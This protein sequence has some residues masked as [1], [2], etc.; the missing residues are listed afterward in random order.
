[1]SFQSAC[2]ELAKSIKQARDDA[3]E[4]GSIR[5]TILVNFGPTSQ[6]LSRYGF[7][8]PTE[9]PENTDSTEKLLFFVLKE[10]KKRIEKT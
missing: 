9:G 7:N 1:M 5:A 3:Y 4:L 10:L 8:I 6:S 2:D